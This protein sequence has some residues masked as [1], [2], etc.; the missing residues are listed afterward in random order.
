MVMLKK[1]KTKSDQNIL[2]NTL[3]NSRGSMPQSPRAPEPPNM[4]I[5]HLLI[6]IHYLYYLILA[7]CLY[8]EVN[9][10]DLMI[11]IV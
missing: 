3:T 9:C 4:L 2:Q 11:K 5:P 10:L 6:A 1:I 7:V 8:M